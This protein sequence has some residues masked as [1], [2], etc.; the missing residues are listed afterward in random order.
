MRERHDNQTA[1]KWL[2]ICVS[3]LERIVIHVDKTGRIYAI[4]RVPA[5]QMK[6]ALLKYR[7]SQA[8]IFTEIDDR[9]T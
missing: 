5:L 7:R 2:V 3:A 4:F 6:D 1:G 8:I 9:L